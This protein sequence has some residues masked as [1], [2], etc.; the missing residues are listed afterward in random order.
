MLERECIDEAQAL[1]VAKE[2]L[3]LAWLACGGPLGMGFLQDRPKATKEEVWDNA[4]NKRDYPGALKPSN[5]KIYADYVFGRMMKLG[6]EISGKSIKFS[7]AKLDREYQ[8]WA[9]VYPTYESLFASAAL[10]VASKTS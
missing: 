10:Y 3:W 8:G 4:V 6:F 9:V 1:S 5:T 2:A 7:D